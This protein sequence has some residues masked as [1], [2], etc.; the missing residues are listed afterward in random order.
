[1]MA[2]R[3]D[4]DDVAVER[5]LTEQ[6]RGLVADLTDVLDLETGLREAMIPGRH[7]RLVAD[8]T[9]VLDL[10]AG[11]AAIVSPTEKQPADNRS[12]QVGGLHAPR[13]AGS[14]PNLIDVMV[15]LPP[16]HR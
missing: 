14:R 12:E 16:A 11:L 3:S 10:G 8:L 2:S 15:A 9:G 13:E 7:R 4:P 5:W 6:R 1:M